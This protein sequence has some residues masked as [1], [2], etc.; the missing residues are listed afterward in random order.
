[1]PE[2]PPRGY[3]K[4]DK[5][6]PHEFFYEFNLDA[7]AQDNT[8]VTFL[9]TTKNSVDPK[10]IEVNKR[11]AAFAVDE[12]PVICFDS[13][14]QKLSFVYMISLPKFVLETDKLSAVQFN[15]FPISGVWE[16]NWTPA[17]D[18]TNNKISDIV[19]VISDPTNE[20]VTPFYNG[21]KLNGAIAVP[22]SNIT[23][24]EA[25]GDYNLTTN[26]N[27]EGVSLSTIQVIYDRMLHFTNAGKL[28]TVIGNIKN[29][30]LTRQKPAFQFTKSVFVRP[31]LRHGNP[32]LFLGEA[33]KVNPS[34]SRNQFFSSAEVST[35]QHLRVS[36]QV[37][38]N[39]WN[40]MFNQSR[41]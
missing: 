26:A 36:I 10:T 19:R 9:R 8:M 1:M 18:L 15:N 25:F 28:K 38:F 13:M 27:Q 6:L 20:D 40:K 5:P 31:N 17:D 32:H 24:P 7:T 12:G 37:R 11:N 33:W 3:D 22:L 2:Q 16:D 23:A 34:S 30:M 39:E 21:T 14:V 35:G 4:Q 29:T 41:M